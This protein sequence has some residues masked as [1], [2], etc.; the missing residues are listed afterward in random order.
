MV[1]GAAMDIRYHN[2][3]AI[4]LAWTSFYGTQKC[5]FI[6]KVGGRASDIRYH[7]TVVLYQH[8]TP[9]KT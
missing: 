6:D 4:L 3:S 2:Y 8:E 9:H 5:V 1:R 7:I